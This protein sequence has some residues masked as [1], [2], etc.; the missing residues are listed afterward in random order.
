M[1]HLERA[2]KPAE[3]A[4]QM[5]EPSLDVINVEEGAVH[6]TKGVG[7]TRPFTD[8]HA[9]A[10]VDFGIGFDEAL[11][12]DF[13]RELESTLIGTLVKS[14]FTPEEDADSDEGGSATIAYERK[15]DD[16][17]I[18]E[19]VHVHGY[20]AHAT[21]F[22]YRGWD[23]TRDQLTDRLRPLLE[24]VRFG[25]AKVSGISLAFRDI[26]ISETP[27]AYSAAEV[28][29][30]SELLPAA[31]FKAGSEWGTQLR[32][33]TGIPS[34]SSDWL[35]VHSR[36]SVSAGIRGSDDEPAE[37]VTSLSH[38]QIA[39]LEESADLSNA[40]T[41]PEVKTCLDV[42]HNRNRDLMLQLLSDEMCSAIGLEKESYE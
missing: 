34:S 3:F 27:D 17:E 35:P 1:R 32:L 16:G 38:H 7:T 4:F 13:L 33:I 12:A 6:V 40:I 5:R 29:K 20:Y 2:R 25:A 36:L 24:Q 23:I 30:P 37:H 42:M 14:G 31:I 26:F 19:L 22:D 15:S 10:S 21:S 18:L 9:I 41:D 11:S 8:A 28:F 39:S